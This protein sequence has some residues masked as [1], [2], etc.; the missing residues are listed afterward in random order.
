MLDSFPEQIELPSYGVGDRQKI[1]GARA[2]YLFPYV[3]EVFSLAELIK[4]GVTI[5]G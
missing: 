4:Q 3:E 2:V 5:D 1:F